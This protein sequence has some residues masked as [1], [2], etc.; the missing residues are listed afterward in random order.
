MEGWG[1]VSL[2]L[3]S[4]ETSEDFVWLHALH[5]PS[6]Q[7]GVFGQAQELL[8]EARSSLSLKSLH[9][10]L[11]ALLQ[12]ETSPTSLLKGRQAPSALL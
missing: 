6:E 4:S 3:A 7:S 2:C 1:G 8:R 9:L 5:S 11:P 12:G 10:A